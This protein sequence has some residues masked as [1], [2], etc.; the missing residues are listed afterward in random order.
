MAAP[1]AGRGGCMA[2][3]S[4]ATRLA[5]VSASAVLLAGGSTAAWAAPAQPDPREA[6]IAQLEQEVQQ[7][8]A[9][10]QKL[11]AD[12]QQLAAQTRALAGEVDQLRQAQVAQGQSLAAEGQAIQTVEAKAPPPPSVIT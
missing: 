8:L 2:G 4:E 7:L 1:K 12:D 10:N 5:G 9:A 6:R 3:W 11:Q